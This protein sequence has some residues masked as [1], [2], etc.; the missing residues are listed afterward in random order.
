MS[1]VETRDRFLQL[2]DVFA[3]DVDLLT[4]EELW[5]LDDGVE[6]IDAFEKLET[7][8]KINWDENE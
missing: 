3:V 1:N 7:M 5:F 8:D 2:L 6:L 4:N